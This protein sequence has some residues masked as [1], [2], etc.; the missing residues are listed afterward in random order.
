MHGANVSLKAQDLLG[1]LSLFNKHSC[2]FPREGREIEV[3]VFYLE[4]IACGLMAA[5]VLFHPSQ[6]RG[7]KSSHLSTH[8]SNEIQQ[9]VVPITPLNHSKRP[10]ETILII[11]HAPKSR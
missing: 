11:G 6:M 8:S 10:P 3:G 7:Y 4:A 9:P 5:R 1:N 2:K